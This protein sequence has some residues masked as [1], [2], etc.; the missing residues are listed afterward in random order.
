LRRTA[1]PLLVAWLLLAAAK[2]PE[3]RRISYRLTPVAEADGTRALAVELR[4]RGDS[5]GETILHLPGAWAGS[6]EL[7]RHATKLEIRG[8]KSLGGYYD[9]P[10]IRHR[11]G[12]RLRVNYRVVSAYAEDPGFAYEKA[13]PIVRSDWFFFHGEGVFSTPEGREAAPA[14][15]RWGKLPPGWRVASDLDHLRRQ[16]STLANM[17]NSVAIGGRELKLVERRVG[18]APLRIA[19]IGHWRFEPEAL[20]DAVEPI[21]EA[22]NAFWH[23]QGS[24]FL[25]AVAPLGEPVAGLSIHGTGRTDAFSIAS[26]GALELAQAK[27]LLGHEYMHSWV[28]IMLG[29]MPEPDEARDY[30]FSEGLTDY[31]ASKTLLRAGIWSLAEYAADKNETLL[32]YGT[33]PVKGASAEEIVERFWNDRD[34]QQLSYDRGHLFAAKL[35]AEIAARTG[36]RQSLDDILR[37]QRKAADGSAELATRL[38]RQTLLDRTGIDAAPEVE[39]HAVKGEPLTL[40]IDLFGDCATIVSERR[41]SFDR[42]FDAEAT[43]IAEGEIAGVDPAGPAYAAGMRDGMI[44]VERVSGTIGDSSLEIA[45][46]VLDEQGVH[47]IRYLPA[48]KTEHEIQH[49]VLTTDGP[50]QEAACRARL[51]GKA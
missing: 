31:L 32:R 16:P 14:R 43:R 45:Y 22:S 26:T 20:A 9:A 33:S 34:I 49:M 42:G 19:M 30:W 23:E 35:D 38:F 1:F 4:F 12:A 47:L 48:G 2:A 10:V 7:W 50:E 40:P 44:M 46:R 27:R 29:R 3:E 15:F 21:V 13:R 37:A 8:A 39:R 25:V 36:G 5:D 11:P 24:P 51:G 6:G 17:I 41:K 28:P 18:N